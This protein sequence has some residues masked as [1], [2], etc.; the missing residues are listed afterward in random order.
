MQRWRGLKMMRSSFRACGLAVAVTAACGNPSP[1]PPD[2]GPAAAWHVVLQRLEPALL[3][4]WGTA[5]DHVFAVGGPRGNGGPS[6]VLRYDGHLWRDLSSSLAPGHTETFWWAHGTS[7]GD[8]WLVGENGRITHYDGNVFTEY[9]SGT[10][11]TLYGVW[12]NATDDVWAVGGTPEGG[13]SQPNDVVVHFDG[14]A[15]S[16]SP[17]P[18]MLGRAF[19][20]VWGTGADNLYIVG[21]AATIWH[22]TGATW[23]L[24]MNP[25]KRNLTTVAGCSSSELYAVGGRDVLRSDGTTWTSVNVSLTNDVSGV[26][27]ARP[28]NV[29]IVG[30]GGL[31]A[32]MVDAMWQDDFGAEPYNTDL[33]GAWASPEGDYWAAGGDYITDP[34]P[35]AARLG[36]VGYYGRRVPSSAI[37]P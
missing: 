28:G 18:Q 26:A 16:P 14:V 3:C 25:A 13:T 11:A 12:A 15:W 30:S 1:P 22:R 35:G 31:K 32:R 17:L 34:S 2:A 4:V 23:A 24:E 9:V 29:V 21:E 19:F 8:V 33:H 36:V 37:A 6:A 7:P 20:K 10:T 5:S 27:C